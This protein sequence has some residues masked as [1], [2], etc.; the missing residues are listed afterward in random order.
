MSTDAIIETTELTKLYNGQ[1]AVE[2]LTFSCCW[3]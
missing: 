2:N 3:A 1:A